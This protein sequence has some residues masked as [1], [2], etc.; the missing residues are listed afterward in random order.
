M[1]KISKNLIIAI[2]LIIALTSFHK[3]N[4]LNYYKHNQIKESI[5]KHPEKLETKEAAIKTSF[6]FK[7]LKADIYRLETIQYIG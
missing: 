5:I 7:N 4:S 3:V 2:I 1:K 6:G